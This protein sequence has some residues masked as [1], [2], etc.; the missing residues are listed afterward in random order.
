MV[1]GVI[2]ISLWYSIPDFGAYW[3]HEKY[4][5]FSQLPLF[6]TTYVY[7][8]GGFNGVLGNAGSL[9]KPKQSHALVAITMPALATL[10]L[11]YAA[12]TETAGRGTCDIILD[13]LPAVC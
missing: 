9:A 10:Y 1:F 13:C 5:D 3:E 12:I 2:G 8:I 4:F 11:P 7:G 6:M